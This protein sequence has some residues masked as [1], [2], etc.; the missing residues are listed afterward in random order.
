MGAQT[1]YDLCFNR[2]GIS[3][4]TYSID[5]PNGMCS[6][7]VRSDVTGDRLRVSSS[8]AN[9]GTLETS[10]VDV[11]ASRRRYYAAVKLGF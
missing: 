5:D 9:L 11:Q 6:R 1:T 7:I 10:G 8:Y 3:N 4:P 2:D